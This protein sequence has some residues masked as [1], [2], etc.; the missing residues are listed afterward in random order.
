MKDTVL[1]VMPAYNEEKRIKNTI[2][3]WKKS[4]IK[5][6]PGSELLI[7]NDG[8]KD[9]TLK[10]LKKINKSNK[11]LKVITKKN[12]GHG[13]TVYKCYLAAISK[14][15]KWIFQTDSD[16]HFN[17]KDFFKLWKR[18]H[19]SE[20]ILGK[21]MNRHDPQFR[22]VLSAIIKLFSSIFFGSTFSDLNI[23]FRLIKKSY[24][25]KIIRKVPEKV[26]APNI[27]LSI[28]AIRDKVDTLDIPIKHNSVGHPS[29]NNIKIINGAIRG[30][31]ELINFW[32]TQIANLNNVKQKQTS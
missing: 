17:P 14:K 19:E 32:F 9:N 15:H 22:I 20:F 5:K 16:G 7:I 8:S 29:T 25:K 26:F 1:V 13:I 6:L 3:M 11:F 4:V 2:L 21:R 28:I 24:L 31:A 30:F 23:P 27:F 10:I 12:E 18:R